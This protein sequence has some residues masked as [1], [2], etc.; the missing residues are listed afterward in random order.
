MA[1]GDAA[2]GRDPSGGIALGL[3]EKDTGYVIPAYGDE[4]SG[5]QNVCLYKW[6][7]SS[8]VWERWDGRMDTIVSGD[9]IIAVDGLETLIGA[10][11]SLLTSILAAVDGLEALLTSIHGDVD[12]VE[13]LLTTISGNVDGVETSLA[14]LAADSTYSLKQYQLSNYDTTTSTIYVGY[15]DKDGNYFIKRINTSTG[16][17][18]YSK[19]TSGYSTAWTNRATQTYNVFSTE[20]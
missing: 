7:T 13:G 2:L 5:G 19:G 20:F 4:V 15:L 12:G 16:A 10:G 9:L 3:T 8:L 1:I 6:N 11:N 18:D 17:V 14:S